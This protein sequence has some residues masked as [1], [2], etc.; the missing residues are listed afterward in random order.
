MVVEAVTRR[1]A[2]GNAPPTDRDGFLIEDL[3]VVSNWIGGLV[4]GVLEATGLAERDLQEDAVAAY[5]YMLVGSIVL[6]LL[7]NLPLVAA[8]G[9]L[10]G[11]A[12]HPPA[13]SASKI[14]RIVY[15]RINES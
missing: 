9:G 1:A 11:V 5:V 8:L 4:G 2:G 3:A 12:A 6:V 13:K 10:V 7:I 15:R 14:A